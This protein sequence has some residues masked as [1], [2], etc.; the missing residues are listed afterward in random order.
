MMHLAI[1]KFGQWDITGLGKDRGLLSAEQCP[2]LRSD[3]RMWL[4]TDTHIPNWC[5][6]QG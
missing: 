4:R 5:K 1:Q 3:G 6:S 2:D